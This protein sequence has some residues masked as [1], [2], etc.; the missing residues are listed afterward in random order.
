MSVMMSD[1]CF[2][3][4]GGGG[5]PQVVAAMREED[6]LCLGVKRGHAQLMLKR[7]PALLIASAVAAALDSAP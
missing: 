2:V 6:L 4:F 5:N 7:V 3:G 1:L